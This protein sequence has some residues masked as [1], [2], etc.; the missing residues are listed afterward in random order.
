MVFDKNGRD[1]REFGDPEPLAE[2]QELN[3]I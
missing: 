2:R 3:V 1:V